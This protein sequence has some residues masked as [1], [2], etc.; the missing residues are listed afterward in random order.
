VGHYVLDVL[1]GNPD[2]HYYLLVRNPQKLRLDLRQYP[3]V[4]LIQEDLAN[5]ESHA[6]LL[7]EI[8]YL[9]HLAADWGGNEGNFD[10]TLLLF[11]LL[12]PVRIK[13]VIYFSTAS[14][15]GSDNRPVFAAEKYGTHYIRSKYRIYKTIPSLRIADKIITIFP[16]WVLGGDSRH[17]Y[18]HAL[19]GILDLAKWFWLIKYFT[20][21]LSFHFIHA[22]DMAR[23]VKYLLENDRPERAYVLGNEPIT[24]T[25]FL[26]EVGSFYGQKVGF[27]LPISLTL[28]QLLA[29]LTWRLLHPWDIYSMNRK[30]FIH[31]TVQARDFGLPTDLTTIA[32]ILQST[33]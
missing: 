12:D 10:Y 23:I 6:R 4:T 9:V 28:V 17:P 16:T 13:K 1:L 7:K 18:S 32:S 33:K 11:N 31:Q 15:L 19:K 20:I 5:I 26:R 27:Q 8:D 14:I 22:R 24:A 29:K 3:N 30:H 25:A 2:H 21:N